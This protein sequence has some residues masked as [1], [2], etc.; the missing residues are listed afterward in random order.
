MSREILSLAS[1]DLACYAVAQFPAFELAV[2]TRLIVD[3][4]EA[5][6]SGKIKRLMV[7]FSPRHGK[8]LLSTQLF[9]DWYLGKH[10]TTPPSARAIHRT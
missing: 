5:I 6:E 7:F 3:K 10:Q 2:H 1:H 4:L 9:P 8:S